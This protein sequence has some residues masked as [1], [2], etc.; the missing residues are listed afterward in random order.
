MNFLCDVL[1]WATIACIVLTFVF[2]AI[3]VVMMFVAVLWLELRTV[4]GGRGSQDSGSDETTL[5][6]SLV[7]LGL[8]LREI[9]SGWSGDR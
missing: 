9:F 7:L 1:L 3:A 8:S 6:S 5:L 2:L 4:F